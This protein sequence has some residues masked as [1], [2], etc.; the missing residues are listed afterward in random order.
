MN[1]KSL[2][3]GTHLYLHNVSF[4]ADVVG[5]EYKINLKIFNSSNSLIKNWSEISDY[6]MNVCDGQI[7]C[8]GYSTSGYYPLALHCIQGSTQKY[9]RVSV[10]GTSNFS[11][12]SNTEQEY[13]VIKSTPIFQS[14]D[15][16][17]INDRVIQIL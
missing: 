14:D 15:C 17:N 13:V 5:Y 2:K 7:P 8:C 3:G 12:D 9:T 6:V 11:Q 4:T 10:V 1:Y 16:T